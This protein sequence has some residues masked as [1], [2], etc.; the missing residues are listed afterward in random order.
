M[1][2]SFFFKLTR[3][4]RL[5]L[6]AQVCHSRDRFV[7]EIRQKVSMENG[8]IKISLFKFDLC[9]LNRGRVRVTTV[10]GDWLPKIKHNIA[11]PG[12]V[13]MMTGLPPRG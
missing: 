2:N 3:L 6:E 9:I 13:M 1:D 7:A 5:R 8:I 12:R 11:I 10:P 4:I